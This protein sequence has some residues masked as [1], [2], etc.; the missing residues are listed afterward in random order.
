LAAAQDALSRHATYLAI[1]TNH[2]QA[3]GSMTDRKIEA[4]LQSYGYDAISEA[5]PLMT[6]WARPKTV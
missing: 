1:D 4:I 5:K 2:P 6:T 3:D